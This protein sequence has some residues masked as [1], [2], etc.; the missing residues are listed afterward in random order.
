M[1]RPQVFFDLHDGHLPLTPEIKEG[2]EQTLSGDLPDDNCGE[3]SGEGYSCTLKAG[4]A[5]LHIA[6]GTVSPPHEVYAV[7][8]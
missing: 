2:V 4:H 7:W 8:E 6:T 3:L 5:G 1:D